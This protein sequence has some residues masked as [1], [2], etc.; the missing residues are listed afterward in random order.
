MGEQ[1]P[2]YEEPWGVSTDGIASHLMV[3]STILVQY[4]WLARKYP[5]LVQLQ[6]MSARHHAYYCAGSFQ[7]W[8]STLVVG[9]RVG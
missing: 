3:L 4:Q 6:T 8:K 2:F 9:N 7:M 1:T 5:R